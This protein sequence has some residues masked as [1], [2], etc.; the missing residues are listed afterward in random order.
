MN[1]FEAQKRLEVEP[2]TSE[3]SKFEAYW[4]GQAVEKEGLP[5]GVY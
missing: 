3:R 4:Y 1:R 2:P 5:F